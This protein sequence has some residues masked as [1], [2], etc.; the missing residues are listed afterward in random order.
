[1]KVGIGFIRKVNAVELKKKLPQDEALHYQI[2]YF[3]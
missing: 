3:Y 2:F 1:M